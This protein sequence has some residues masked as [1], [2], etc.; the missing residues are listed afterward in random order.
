M[1]AAKKTVAQWCVRIAYALVFCI[2]VS[3]ALQFA[4]CPENYAAAYELSGV[5]G[6]TAIQGI[7][8]AFLMWNCTYPLVIWK[9][10]RFMSLAWVVLVQQ[11]VGLAG[12]S[13]LL[14]GLPAGHALLKASVM[15]FIAFDASGFF[16]MVS[17]VLFLVT[18]VRKA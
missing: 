9:P 3:C 18:T 15:R 12:E 1:L 8:I 14:W 16:L 5:A 2:N 10:T 17:A 7:G 11:T 4:C 6:C 13:V